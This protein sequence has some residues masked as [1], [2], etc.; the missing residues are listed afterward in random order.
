MNV[1]GSIEDVVGVGISGGGA[2]T[3]ANNTTY[4]LSEWER[5][6]NFFQ[7]KYSSQHIESP[8]KCKSHCCTYGLNS[9][10]DY[11]HDHREGC[12]KLCSQPF[13]VF[14]KV[15]KLIDNVLRQLIEE[16][17]LKERDEVQAMLEESEKI[18]LPT[19]TQ[20]MT[21]RV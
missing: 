7:Y 21:H 5:L 20:Y 10:L 9:E 19:V 17:R 13:I 2:P 12:C 18:F 8:S 14:D 3:T 1:L 15:Q 4:I 11:T 6:G 16:E